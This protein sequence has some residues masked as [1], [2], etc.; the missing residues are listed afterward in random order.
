MNHIKIS[1]YLSV[2]I[3][4]LFSGQDFSG[5]SNF[6]CGHG[7]H[8]AT[9]PLGIPTLLEADDSYVSFKLL[10]PAVS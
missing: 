8:L 2:L 1:L 10:E 7:S 3:I 9:L 6:P 4:S 5:V